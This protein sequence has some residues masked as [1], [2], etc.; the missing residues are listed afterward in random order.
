MTTK[1]PPR[2]LPVELVDGPG[3]MLYLFARAPLTPDECDALGALLS[4]R[5]AAVRDHVTPAHPPSER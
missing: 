3:D 1:T 2:P 4:A 5:A